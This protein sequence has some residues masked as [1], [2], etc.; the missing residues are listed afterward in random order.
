MIDE[1]TETVQ[2]MSAKCAGTL[3]AA[4][5]IE[6]EIAEKDYVRASMPV[7]A[8]TRQC[9]GLLHGGASAALAE[10]LGSFGAWLNVDRTTTGVVGVQINANHLRS[11][12]EGRVIG[13]ARPLHRGRRTQVWEVKIETEDQ[14]LVCVSQCTVMNIP[15]KQGK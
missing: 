1:K 2:E 11:V 10:T 3:M 7:D 14:Q 13:H 5:G 12:S 4:L 15:L 6:F 9:V 8:R